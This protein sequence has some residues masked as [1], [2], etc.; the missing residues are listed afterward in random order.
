MK[1]EFNKVVE[2]HL[3]EGARCYD[4]IG[5]CS[6]YVPITEALIRACLR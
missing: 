4:L 3:V 5:A 2:L 6:R 1:L